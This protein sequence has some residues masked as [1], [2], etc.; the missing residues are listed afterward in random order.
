MT[1]GGA[2]HFSLRHDSLGSMMKPWGIWLAIWAVLFFCTHARSEKPALPRRYDIQFSRWMPVNIDTITQEGQVAAAGQRSVAHVREP[3][4]EII[5]FDLPFVCWRS[6]KSGILYLGQEMRFYVSQDD[7]VIGL[8]H[9]FMGGAIP[10]EICRSKA[11]Q[12]D[13]A[14]MRDSYQSSAQESD[15]AI[16]IVKTQLRLDKFPGLNF[17]FP[18]LSSQVTT[19]T[20][21]DK[22][23]LVGEEMTLYLTNLVKIKGAPVKRK[24]EV[25]FSVSTLQIKSARMDDAK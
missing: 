13:I 24:A 7:K 18:N 22:V 12:E 3:K 4:K 5:H 11:A 15:S 23:T 2:L 20:I 6:E 25:T 14:K 19:T 1:P 8:P 17:W 10:V 16:L 21:V 9:Y